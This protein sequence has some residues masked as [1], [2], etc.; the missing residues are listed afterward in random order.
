MHSPSLSR[1]ALTSSH[2]KTTS[3][4]KS[5]TATRLTGLTQRVSGFHSTLETDLHQ[6]RSEDENR[7][8][9]IRDAIAHLDHLLQAETKRRAD[10]LDALRT[11]VE[12]SIHELQER[13]SSELDG[14][15]EGLS[16][17]LSA[18]NGRVSGL[19][20]ALQEQGRKHQE[21]IRRA[22][23]SS[24]AA[25]ASLREAVAA[26]T[27]ERKEAAATINQRIT[28]DGERLTTAIEEETTRRETAVGAADEESRTRAEQL[29]QRVANR[30]GSLGS[31]IEELRSNVQGESAERVSSEER[32]VNTL[33]EVVSRLQ[34]GLALVSKQ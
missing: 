28:T 1:S 5:P 24:Q 31:D 29:G 7:I 6:R 9:L 21:A 4:P 25:V 2:L 3:A 14:L 33:D 12:G 30:F 13:L 34:A 15:S 8:Q 17:S 32:I 26:E 18:L 23:A 22:Q 27:A 16:E 20:S 10:T 11:S 19:E